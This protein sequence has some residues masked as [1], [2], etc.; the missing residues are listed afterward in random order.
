MGWVVSRGHSPSGTEELFES[1][2]ERTESED[3]LGPEEN[4]IPEIETLAS[5]AGFGDITSR[6]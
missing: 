2:E 3:R 1:G 4:R 6:A 5:I